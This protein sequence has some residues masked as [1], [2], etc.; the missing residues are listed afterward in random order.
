MGRSLAENDGE[1]VG[2]EEF[3]GAGGV[4][5][6]EAAEADLGEESVV[7]EEFVFPQN[8]VDDLLGATGE[9]RTARGRPKRT[10]GSI[11]PRA[12]SS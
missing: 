8:L 12:S 7:A 6:G 2:G 5:E 4:G 10:R 11:T 9:Q 1:D 3:D